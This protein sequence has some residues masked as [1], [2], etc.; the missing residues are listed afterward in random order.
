MHKRTK[1]YSSTIGFG[2]K[3]AQLTET[4]L[5]STASFANIPVAANQYNFTGASLFPG[6]DIC[7]PGRVFHI[8]MWMPFYGINYIKTRFVKQCYYFTCLKED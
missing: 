5:Q 2:T 3:I 4:R 6:P 7:P 8:F 1:L